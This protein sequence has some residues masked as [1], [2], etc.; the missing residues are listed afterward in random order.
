MLLKFGCRNASDECTC[1][2][3]YESR[4]WQRQSN[5]YLCA[6]IHGRFQKEYPMGLRELGFAQEH[7]A[8]IKELADENKAWLLEELPIL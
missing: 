3:V 2:Y 1:T 5:L 8:Y 6:E 7:V 4:R